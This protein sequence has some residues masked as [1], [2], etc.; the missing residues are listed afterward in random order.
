[1]VMGKH[2][3]SSTKWYPLDGGEGVS[4]SFEN[5]QNTND[6]SVLPSS[7][8]T[9]RSRRG[10]SWLHLHCAALR[11]TSMQLLCLHSAASLLRR[12]RVRCSSGSTVRKVHNITVAAAARRPVPAT[13][14]RLHPARR[15]EAW[16]V[17]VPQ[18]RC[19]SCHP[20]CQ[21]PELTTYRLHYYNVQ[22]E[23]LRADGF[24]PRRSPPTLALPERPR[25]AWY[26]PKSA[27]AQRAPINSERGHPTALLLRCYLHSPPPLFKAVRVFCGPW[28]RARARRRAQSMR[29]NY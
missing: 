21:K 17:V 23:D 10:H 18:S 25:D 7:R 13:L 29:G 16:C 19:C 14:H 26:S 11:C 9:T 4:L 8:C 3:S 6:P 15:E 24:D 28:R 2:K 1:M 22:D 27:R 12:R 5:N 20:S